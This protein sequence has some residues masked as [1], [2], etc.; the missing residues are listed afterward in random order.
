M[1]NK[2][3]ATNS[4][5]LFMKREV[6]TLCVFV[7]L[8]SSLICTCAAKERFVQF[9]CKDGLKTS[10][11]VQAYS[12]SGCNGKFRDLD[13]QKKLRIYR[14]AKCVDSAYADERVPDGLDANRLNGAVQCFV[15]LLF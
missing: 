8:I 6:Q 11:F 3:G 7:L 15:P 10:Q 9:N 1:E 13:G 4:H 12:Y 2:Y 14:M 5:P